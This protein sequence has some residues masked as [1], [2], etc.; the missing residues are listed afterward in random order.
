MDLSQLVDVDTTG[1]SPLWVDC[2]LFIFLFLLHCRYIYECILSLD[3]SIFNHLSRAFVY[4]VQRVMSLPSVI[5]PPPSWT[6]SWIEIFLHEVLLI[7]LCDSMRFCTHQN[8]FQQLIGNLDRDLQFA[9]TVEGKMSI[10]SI[11]NYK[12]VKNAIMEKVLFFT[13]Y[14]MLKF[15]MSH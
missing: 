11:A 8:F 9:I 2:W 10:E 5:F 3:L 4:L 6:F 13:V 12:D 14:S 7:H 1:G 15:Q